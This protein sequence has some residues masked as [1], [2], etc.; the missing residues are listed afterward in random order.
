MATVKKVKKAQNGMGP[1]PMNSSKPKFKGP[2]GPGRESPFS[3]LGKPK[4]GGLKPSKPDTGTKK[5]SPEEFMKK[6]KT[7]S[8]KPSPLTPMKKGGK[9]KKAQFGTMEKKTSPGGMYK[10]RIFRDANGKIVK[11]TQRRTL[12]GFLSGA[13]RGAGKKASMKKGGKISK[14]K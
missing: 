11:E 5:F 8:E 13:P 9:V 14:K 1:K 7:S 3:G 2:Q 4:V 10:S 12:K 6:R